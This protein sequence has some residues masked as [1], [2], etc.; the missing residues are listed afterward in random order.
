M[1]N[2]IP[3]KKSWKAIGIMS[4]TS[5]DGLDL[6]AVH[7]SRV[8][9]K[10]AFEMVATETVAYSP[11][12][13]KKLGNAHLL[14]AR[15]LTFLDAEF[16]RFLGHNAKSFMESKH[17]L[18][19][20]IAS[21][22]HTIFHQPD[23][24]FTFQIG[25][26]AYISAESGCTVVSDFRTLDVAL[27]GQG[28]PLVPIGDKLLFEAYDY[29]LN[30]GGFSN[31]SFDKNGK[32]QAYDICPV[33]IALND[34][35]GKHG[36]KFD[37]NGHLGRKGEL[38]NGLLTKLNSL[39]YYTKTPPK[40]L[41]REWYESIFKPVLHK[42]YDS[43]SNKLRTVY[44]HIAQQTAIQATGGKMLV[45]GGGAFNTFLIERIKA[46]GDFDLV[47]PENQIVEYKE[48][49]I[50]AFLGLLRIENKLN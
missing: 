2:N 23:N 49:L 44:E 46:L 47:I 33:N 28:A 3:H 17:F 40:S 35:A 45:T 32:R 8:G 18:P 9:Q 20:F 11:T 34:F 25:N 38:N 30:L 19:D 5:L 50:F 1:H 39:S 41:G 31:I 42:T 21:H 36:L 26:G 6:V 22:G 48:A 14:N 10:W 15:E 27:G 4:G 24:K 43:A 37:E 16:G 29:C 13:L 12:W 7:F